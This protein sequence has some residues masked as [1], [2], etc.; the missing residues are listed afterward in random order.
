MDQLANKTAYGSAEWRRER[1]GARMSL[2]GSGLLFLAFPL[3]HE[4]DFLPTLAT[5]RVM[6]IALVSTLHDGTEVQL[7]RAF[8]AAKRSSPAEATLEPNRGPALHGRVT[9]Y[10][11]VTADTAA[12][13]HAELATFTDALRAAFPSWEENLVVTPDYSTVPAPNELSRRIAFGTQAAVLLMMLGGQF[14]MVIGAHRAGTGRARIFA[15]LATPFIILINSVFFPAD[16]D[17]VLADFHYAVSKGEW[18]FLLLLLAVTPASVILSL[19]LTR[20][21]RPVAG[22]HR[23]A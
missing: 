17:D 3:W 13:A 10:L 1:S 7:Q 18:K 14:L 22:Q 11:S 20:R 8:A 6:A 15:A 16:S 9:Y 5:K 2:V 23:R 4:R 12:R 19:W 21:P